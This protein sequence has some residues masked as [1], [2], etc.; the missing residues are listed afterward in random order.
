MVSDLTDWQWLTGGP[1]YDWIPEPLP[2]VSSSYLDSVVENELESTGDALEVHDTLADERARQFRDDPAY[3]AAVREHVRSTGVTTFGSTLISFGQANSQGWDS[4]V[5]AIRRIQTYVDAAEWLTKALSPTDLRSSGVSIL[6]QLE[7]TV[8]LEK[9][10]SRL[11]ELYDFGVRTI[12]LTYNDRNLV[13]DGCSERTDAGLSSFGLEVIERANELGM[14][15][16]LS[17]CGDATTI[18][19]IDVSNAPPAA[20]HVF[21]RS[22]RDGERGKSDAVLERLATTGGY[23]GI[24][25]IPF[26]QRDPNGFEAMLDHVDHAVEILGVDQVGIGTNWGIWTP[27]VP[28][29]LQDG[30]YRTLGDHLSEK[31]DRR[32]MGV[33]LPPMDTYDDWKEIPDGLASRGYSPEEVRLLCGGSFTEYFE[34]VV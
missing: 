27:E 14:M 6:L 10:L 17:H 12:Q 23:V 9:S 8:A 29:P 11:D 1:V 24:T 5:R 28:P 7:D 3:R 16:E 34:R 2:P 32:T 13:G 30:I 20:S 33:G 4:V 21:C 19:A 18:E 31:A 15:I 26:F 22:L 25:A